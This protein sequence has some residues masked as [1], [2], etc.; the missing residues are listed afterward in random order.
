MGRHAYKSAYLGLDDH[1]FVIFGDGG[2]DARTIE[3]LALASS[4]LAATS[5]LEVISRKWWS[6][7]RGAADRAVAEARVP[8]RWRWIG[9]LWGKPG[10]DASIQS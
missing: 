8:D 6:A 7:G 1:H 10:P 4:R 5:L 9:R 3:P 2:G